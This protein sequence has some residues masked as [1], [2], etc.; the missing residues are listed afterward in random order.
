MTVIT[1]MVISNDSIR[2]NFETFS[3]IFFGLKAFC[4]YLQLINVT[5]C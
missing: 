1:F 5:I 2:I 4:V 3:E